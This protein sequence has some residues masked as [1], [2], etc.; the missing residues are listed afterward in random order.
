MVQAWAPRSQKEYTAGCA[1]T[2]RTDHLAQRP[3]C[4]PQNSGSQIPGFWTSRSSTRVPSCLLPLPL[5]PP[6]SRSPRVAEQGLDHPLDCL[7]SLL[8]FGPPPS[9]ATPL[10][11]MDTVGPCPSAAKD[12][13]RQSEWKKCWQRRLP[14]T[15][16]GVSLSELPTQSP[17]PDRQIE[18]MSASAHYYSPHLCG[19]LQTVLVGFSNL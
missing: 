3:G 7:G 8:R 16:S 19:L 17:K 4:M 15:K 18:Q 12:F 14:T 9:R 10:G 2:T 13:K 11:S 5:P 6:E 1:V